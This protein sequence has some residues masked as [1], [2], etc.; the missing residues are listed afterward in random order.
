[1]WDLCAEMWALPRGYRQHA[2]ELFAPHCRTWA[3]RRFGF[4]T[5]NFVPFI[6]SSKLSLLPVLSVSALAFLWLLLNLL[7]DGGPAHHTHSSSVQLSLLYHWLMQDRSA[8]LKQAAHEEPDVGLYPGSQ[9]Q[10]LSQSRHPTAEPSRHP[11]FFLKI[12]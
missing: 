6:Y 4:L 1:M 11:S 12:F 9:D 3:T 10:D 8:D 7:R 5:S 2:V